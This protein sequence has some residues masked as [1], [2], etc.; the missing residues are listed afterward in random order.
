MAILN[1]KPNI[2]IHDN[3]KRTC[4]LTEIVILGNR[5]VIK[6]E[7]EKFLTYKFLTV[8]IQRMWNLKKL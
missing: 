4:L 3:E 1:T 2:I 7:T 6:K 8:E 5:N